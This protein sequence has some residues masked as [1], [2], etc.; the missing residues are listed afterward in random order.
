MIVYNKNEYRNRPEQILENKEQIAKHW[1]VDRVLADYGIQIQGQRD[2]FEEIANL[3]EGENYGYAYLIGPEAP[4]TTYIWTRADINAGET[5]PYWLNIGSI[6]IVGPQGP[7]GDKG[8]KGEKGSK[9]DKGDKGDTGATGAQG[10]QG[11]QGPKGEKG[12]VGPRGLPGEPT[13]YI[14]IKGILTSTSQLPDAASTP[15]TDAYLIGASVPYSM[16]LVVE[17]VWKMVGSFNGSGTLVKVYGT[18]RYTLDLDEFVLMKPNAPGTSANGGATAVAVVPTIDPDTGE[19]ELGG[20]G[21]LVNDP[22]TMT[23]AS[24]YGGEYN[25]PVYGYG[26]IQNAG[27]LKARNPRNYTFGT[28]EVTNPDTMTPNSTNGWDPNIL[29]N[30]QTLCRVCNEISNKFTK[31]GDKITPSNFYDNTVSV[32]N[33][34]TNEE[35]LFNLGTYSGSVDSEIGSW[36]LLDFFSETDE[37]DFSTPEFKYAGWQFG[38]AT[39]DQTKGMVYQTATQ[40]PAHEENEDPARYYS[41]TFVLNM[42][43]QQYFDWFIDEVTQVTFDLYLNNGAKKT[44]KVCVPDY[45]NEEDPDLFIITSYSAKGREFNV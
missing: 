36:Y 3:N 18:N 23:S 38:G 19:I 22:S 6:S 45:Y 14:Q 35:F 4:Y 33:P 8:D 12:E 31:W 26:H 16:Y 13:A 20:A 34:T 30:L 10:K 7:K 25:I 39:V 28:L 21:Y 27:V 40:I 32:K 29:V 11:A 42:K 17:G 2:T 15:T 37:G 44:I 41:G 5:E 43:D 9:G 24:Y 1:T